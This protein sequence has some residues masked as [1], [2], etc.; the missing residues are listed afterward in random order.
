MNKQ[1]QDK[2]RAARLEFDSRIAREIVENRQ[3]SYREIATRFGVSHDWV[4][5]VAKQFNIKRPSGRKPGV[6]IRD[7]R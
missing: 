4:L 7:R 1:L 5:A 6:P 3:K 2:V